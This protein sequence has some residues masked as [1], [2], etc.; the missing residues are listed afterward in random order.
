MVPAARDERHQASGSA[1][2]SAGARAVPETG[3]TADVHRC[4]AENKQKGKRM[5]LK[6]STTTKVT[7]IP[8]AAWAAQTEYRHS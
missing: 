2:R 7:W 5:A 1:P 8:A 6:G 3:A 4:I